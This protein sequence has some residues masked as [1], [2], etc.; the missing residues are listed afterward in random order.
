MNIKLD[1]EQKDLSMREHV[2]FFHSS[3]PTSDCYSFKLTLVKFMQKSL[4]YYFVPVFLY[5]QMLFGH[6][7]SAATSRD[8]T[9]QYLNKT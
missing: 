8:F 4:L 7:C 5:L 1:Y 9:A 3:I 2:S 6:S